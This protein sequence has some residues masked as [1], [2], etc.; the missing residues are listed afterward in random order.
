MV[1]PGASGLAMVRTTSWLGFHWMSARFS[2]TVL[3]VMVRQS[4][5]TRPASIKA[6]ITMGT[7]P[8]R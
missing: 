1:P 8:A 2:F 3:P 4:P 7:P 6:F 5:F